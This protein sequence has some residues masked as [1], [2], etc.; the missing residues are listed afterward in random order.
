MAA[1]KQA[2][3]ADSIRLLPSVPWNEWQGWVEPRVNAL[4]DL[5]L[6]RQRDDEDWVHDVRVATRRLQEVLEMGRP[7]TARA[8][9]VIAAARRLRQ[10]LGALRTYDVLLTE[11]EALEAHHA[12]HPERRRKLRRGVAKRRKASERAFEREV[13]PGL[14]KDRKR[15]LRLAR[16]AEKTNARDLIATHLHDRALSAQYLLSSLDYP[17]EGRNHHRLR[18]TI[19]KVRYALEI[20]APV[21]FELP[22]DDLIAGLKRHQ[23]VLGELNDA[24][25]LERFVS[26]P[27]ILKQ[28]GDQRPAFEDETRRSRKVRFE[29][30]RREVKDELPELL[31]RLRRAAG[32]SGKLWH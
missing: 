26:L 9:P 4:Y 25:D 20:G 15:A 19:K 29:R 8:G 23:D 5:A 31:G 28:L 24:W 30:A 10:G 27:W 3:R 21:L 11:L 18:L 14:A 1:T 13:A 17:S 7:A 22:S 6:K 2:P 16:N 32:K 12:L